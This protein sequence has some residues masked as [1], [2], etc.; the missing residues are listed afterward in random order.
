MQRK[1]FNFMVLALVAVALTVTNLSHAAMLENTKGEQDFQSA[2]IA[3][4]NHKVIQIMGNCDAQNPPCS[5]FKVALALMGF[6]SG[7]LIDKDSPKW[8]FKK[9]YEANFQSWYKPEMAVSYGWQGEHT[10]ATFLKNS[11]VWFSHQITQRLGKEKFQSYINKLH[12]GNKDVSGTPGQDDGLLNSW[13]ETSL[14]I[15]PR[16]QVE[17]LEQMLNHKLD[18]SKDAQEKTIEI[19]IKKDKD[20]RP[21]EWH[22]W[23]LYGKTGGGTGCHRWFIGWVQKGEDKIIFAQYVGLTKDTPEVRASAPRAIDAAKENILKLIA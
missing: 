16:E 3:K 18:L 14:K 15:S 9:E 19:M 5:T 12:Y 8:A 22:G 17:F 6:D 11:V 10:P 21:I 20:D 2:F 13:L 7:I 23:K 1:S 4:Q